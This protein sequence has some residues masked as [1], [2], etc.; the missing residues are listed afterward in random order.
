M[1]GP[2]G[3]RRTPLDGVDSHPLLEPRPPH[4][5]WI[6]DGESPDIDGATRLSVGPER[7]WLVIDGEVPPAPASVT[8]VSHGMT[9]LRVCGPH[10]E[11]VLTSGIS[12][13]LDQSAFEVGAAAATAFRSIFVLL[14][15]T[16][17]A[18]FD[19]YTPRST[20]SSLWEWL[21]DTAEG[22]QPTMRSN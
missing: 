20:V 7:W 21:V 16:G 9:R 12:L 1:S 4:A 8:D 17:A 11:A 5:I 19:V 3:K 22:F 10:S 6:A 18:A 13:D 14:H 15:R 2:L